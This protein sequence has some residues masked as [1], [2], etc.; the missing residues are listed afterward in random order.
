[1]THEG[2]HWHA[3]SKCF[4]CKQCNLSLLGRAFLPKRG[5]IYC[6][7]QCSEGKLPPHQKSTSIGLYDN[8][9]Q[10]T[11]DLSLSSGISSKPVS[12]ALE[13]VQRD[14]A[15]QRDKVMMMK[16][17]KIP[18]P[19]ME[20]PKVQLNFT[21]FGGFQDT[22]TISGAGL[23]RSGLVFQI[24]KCILS[25]M[26]FI[27]D[28]L[29]CKEETVGENMMKSTKDMEVWVEEKP[30]VG[31]ELVFKITVST[32]TFYPQAKSPWF[33]LRIPPGPS[34]WTC[35]CL[36]M[37]MQRSFI[38]NR[39]MDCKSSVIPSRGIRGRWSQSLPWTRSWLRCWGR[40]WPLFKALRIFHTFN[41]IIHQVYHSTLAIMISD[42]C[43]N[44]S[45]EN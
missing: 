31:N 9:Q 34:K 26:A 6:S 27:S 3:T 37:P 38:E 28:H 13:P 4:R 11:S 30:W 36:A 12:P 8:V 21:E 45:F 24:F 42:N 44:S 41:I 1:M 22:P 33:L 16:K 29:H 5:L 15:D 10:Q 25:L 14:E 39:N 19:V 23:G 20:K 7:V 18:P 17:K 35:P 40:I 2:Q 43:W 32:M